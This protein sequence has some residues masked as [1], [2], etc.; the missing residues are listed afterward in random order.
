M[1]SKIRK[2]S[3]CRICGSEEENNF[4]EVKE[5]FFGTKESFLYFECSDCQCMQI[6]EFP[7]K[8]EHY[9]GENYYSFEQNVVEASAF[10]AEIK[11]KQRILDVGCGSGA[12]L[13]QKAKEGYGYLYGCDPFIEKDI[14]YEGRIEI[15]KGTIY[16]MQGTF[17]L[18]N[19]GDSFEHMED[20]LEELLAVKKLM[21]KDGVCQISIPVYPNIAVETFGVNWFQ[22][23]A[24]RHF[25]LHSKKSM[26]CLCEQAELIIDNIEYDSKLGQ[27]VISFIYELGIPMIQIPD[28][29]GGVFPQEELRKFQEYT[30]FANHNS[31][32]DHAVF[33]LRHK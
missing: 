27:F 32:G 18:I 7:T 29:A 14:Q 20:P 10:P 26:E 28:N 2:K 25:F 22:W 3:K 9:Y 31:A 24:P 8:M 16:D 11:Y 17:D 30:D 5:M 33:T 6:V 4:Y 13:I 1:I 23:D 21:S 15:K 19:F 12:W